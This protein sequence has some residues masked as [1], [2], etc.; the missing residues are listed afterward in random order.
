MELTEIDLNLLAW[1]MVVAAGVALAVRLRAAFE[2]KREADQPY[3]EHVVRVAR[4]PRPAG[5]A[6]GPLVNVPFAA[7]NAAGPDPED[8]VRRLARTLLALA[9]KR[10]PVGAAQARRAAA[11]ITTLAA[12]RG[13]GGEDVERAALAG[14]LLKL[15]PGVLPA[16][17]QPRPER[18]LSSVLMDTAR[19]DGPVP[20][21]VRAIR[22]GA[23]V[24][25]GL[26]PLVS[27]VRE[28]A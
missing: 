27:L 18:E 10:D 22:E 9:D 1:G 19:L 21:I 20:A 12:S 3:E 14:M 25:P 5:M 13:I 26:E 7:A 17:L 2:R 16:G 11:R 8:A 6:P 28:A 23:P 24:E 4:R 15:G